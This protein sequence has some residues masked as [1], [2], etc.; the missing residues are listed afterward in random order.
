MRGKVEDAIDTLL[1]A[2]NEDPYIFHQGPLAELGL[3][4]LA[5]GAKSRT[6]EDILT[7]LYGIDI[8]HDEK[9]IPLISQVMRYG[10]PNLQLVAVQ[11]LSSFDTE[12]A[13]KILEEAMRSD[14]LLVRLE[15]AY[16]LAQ[17]HSPNAYGQLISLMSKVEPE[18]YELFPRLF[19][20]EGSNNSLAEL[21]K[22]LYDQNQLVRKEA[23]LATLAT[24]RDSFIPDLRSL[25]KEP[26]IIQQEACAYTLGAFGDED[27]RDLLERLSHSFSPSVQVAALSALYAI[28]SDDARSRLV[29][30]ARKGDLFAIAELGTID[31]SEV[32]LKDLVNHPDGDVR[33]N[34]ALSL[35]KR[36]SPAALNEVSDIL[37]DSARDITYLPIVSHGGALLAYKRLASSEEL[38]KDEPHFFELSL[39]LK[40]QLLVMCMELDEDDFLSIC[41]EIFESHQLDLVPLTVQLLENIRSEKAIKLLKRE[42]Q[43][44]GAP[45]IRAWCSLSLVR[46]REEGPYLDTIRKM[47]EKYED[48]ELFKARLVLPWRMR[49][50]KSRHELTLDDS[51]ALVI[52]SFATLAEMQDEKGIEALLKAIRNGNPH[53]RYTLAGL[54]MRSSL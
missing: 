32:Y 2:K 33:L 51:C 17:K 15:A 3:E 41:E 18:F 36:R 52:Q 21:R 14:Y 9:G 5:Q 12:E 35:I 27:S 8:S 40:E 28:G 34:V 29:T 23:I 19:A 43:R 7:S 24:G 13:T 50:E 22:L 39:R 54:L 30:M 48:K 31:G 6:P 42:V 10:E 47:V 25:A 45:Y 38:F 20:I 11:V 16:I 26:S 4:L 44:L 46:L 53:N 37:I 1:L 49:Q